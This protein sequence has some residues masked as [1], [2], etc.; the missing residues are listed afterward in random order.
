MDWGFPL[1]RKRADVRIQRYETLALV[2]FVAIPL[3]FTGA[4]L[5]SLIAYLF[6]LPI[7]RSF[8]MIFIDV[9]V[10]FIQLLKHQTR[11]TSYSV[12]SLSTRQAF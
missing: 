3:P 11:S 12:N 1:V 8:L 4:G 6:D 10:L 7:K 5:G 2:I 9:F